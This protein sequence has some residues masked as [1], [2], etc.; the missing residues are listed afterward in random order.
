MSDLR[1]IRLAK[2]A[3]L[4]NAGNEPY[5]VNF[6]ST[7]TTSALQDE[8]KDLPKGEER[9]L[10]VAVGGRVLARRGM[11]KLAFFTLSDESGSIQLFL[12]K[13][14]L[15]EFDLLESVKTELHFSSRHWSSELLE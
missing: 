5:A 12:E 7:H 2:A 1:E 15:E 4:R 6:Q 14:T 10:K 9:N 11:G 13:S 8:H 3:S